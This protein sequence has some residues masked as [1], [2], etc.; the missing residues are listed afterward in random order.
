VLAPAKSLEQMQRIV[1]NDYVNATLTCLLV[2]LVAAMLSFGLVAV[3]RAYVDPR[4][5]A[6]EVGLLAGAE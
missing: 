3:W 1:F 2:A 6:R 4:I 5:T